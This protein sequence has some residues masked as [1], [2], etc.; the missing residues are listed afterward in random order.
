MGIFNCA[1]TL[2]EALESIIAQTFHDWEIILCD[3]CST[4]D[5]IKVAEQ[6]VAK[7]SPKIKLIRNQENMGLNF[8]LNRCLEVAQGEFIA[9]MDGDDLCAP[10]RFEKELAVLRAHP[11]I[12]IVSANMTFFDKNGIWGQTRLK[13]KPL[14]RDFANGTQFCH[15]AAM[16][17]KCAYDDVQGYSVDT[18][19]LRVEDYH[20]WIKMYA[21]G[22]RGL[23]IT[24]VL[25]QM[26]DDRN[27]QKRRTWRNRLNECHVRRLAVQMLHL[28]FYKYC[29]CL[30]PIILGLVPSGLYKLLHKFRNS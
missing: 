23:N 22:Y 2:S 30:R 27:A 28:P 3:D 20:L 26:R 25:Y 6:Y 7:Y 10:E 11:E 24:E 4:D 17:R 1:D 16:V 5:T 9:R 13:T 15:A 8:T 14:P 21:K 18:K 12:A 19:L 29:Y